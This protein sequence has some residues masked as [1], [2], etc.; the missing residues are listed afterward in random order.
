MAADKKALDLII[1]SL[2]RAHDKLDSLEK[3]RADLAVHLEAESNIICEQRRMNDIL[4]KNT[5]SLDLHI[6]RTEILEESMLN[7]CGRVE[8]IEKDFL[9]RKAISDFFKSTGKWVGGALAAAAAV[10]TIVYKFFI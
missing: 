6:K 8:P 1:S 2:E 9:H 4:D 7:V 5:R 10:A 3:M